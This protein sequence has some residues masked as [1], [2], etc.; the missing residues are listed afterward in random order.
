MRPRRVR[1]QQTVRQSARLHDVVAAVGVEADVVFYARLEIGVAIL[2][3]PNVARTVI[4]GSDSQRRVYPNFDSL[5]FQTA[6]RIERKG[7]RGLATVDGAPVCLSNARRRG[8]GSASG[9]TQRRARQ[10]HDQE[11]ADARSPD[12]AR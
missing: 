11:R 2:G 9:G 12:N 6:R 5:Q 1:R 3:E 8:T 10:Q 7:R 4:Q